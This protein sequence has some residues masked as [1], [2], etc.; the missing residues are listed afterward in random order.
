MQNAQKIIQEG[1]TEEQA[2]R[3]LRAE[4]ARHREWL[5]RPVPVLV[6]SS[7]RTR[8]LEGFEPRIGRVFLAR[9]SSGY[10]RYVD[11]L[12]DTLTFSNDSGT[13][14]V[15]GLR[16]VHADSYGDACIHTTNGTK[17]IGYSPLLERYAL[18]DVRPEC[19]CVT[20][21]LVDLSLTPREISRIHEEIAAERFDRELQCELYSYYLV[22]YEMRDTIRG[23]GGPLPV[24]K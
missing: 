9:T 16:F 2:Q 19:H 1:E 24:L 20:G 13:I 10:P 12:D 3:R 8:C 6:Q 23:M 17:K 7:L 4:L 14:S 18:C 15:A 5:E 11:V 22:I 21:P